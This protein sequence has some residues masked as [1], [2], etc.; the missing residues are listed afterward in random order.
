M[1]NSP[2]EESNPEKPENTQEELEK[3]ENTEETK[4][5][6][7]NTEEKKEE[8][9]KKEDFKEEPEKKE[10]IKEEIKIEEEKPEIPKEEVKEQNDEKELSPE[11]E[12]KKDLYDAIQDLKPEEASD[13]IKSK[14]ILMTDVYLDCKKVEREEYAKEYD[15]LQDKYDQKYQDLDERIDIIV[16]SKEKI[17]LTQEEKDQYGIKDDEEETKPIDDYWEKV[18]INSLYF[19]ITDRDKIILKYLTKVKTVKFPDNVNDFR[20]DFY[21]KENEFFSNKILSKKYIYGKESTLKKAEGTI[22]EW[23]SPEKN[24][25]IEKVKK[26]IKEEKNFIMKKR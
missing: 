2:K 15:I 9:E 26:K 25:T 14:L 18:I 23:K 1:E 3:P 10:E 7:E 17:E 24:T 8:P 16:N 4:E 20:V 21:F 5:K 22:I 12:D 19:T 13:N 6:P 11:E